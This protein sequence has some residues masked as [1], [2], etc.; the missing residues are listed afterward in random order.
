M[1]SLSC[2]INS[3]AIMPVG[4]YP[5]HW[6]TLTPRVLND[7]ASFQRQLTTLRIFRARWLTAPSL[8]VN[9]YHIHLMRTS[10]GKSSLFMI[11]TA[12]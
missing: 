2:V 1:N 4:L 3:S 7:Q 6:F 10:L 8:D 9:S 12:Y 5:A 11:R